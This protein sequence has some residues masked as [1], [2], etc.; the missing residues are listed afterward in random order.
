MVAVAPQQTLPGTQ[1]KSSSIDTDA[2]EVA[3]LGALAP[4]NFK[5][6]EVTVSGDH[7]FITPS[8]VTGEALHLSYVIS[9]QDHE[10]VSVFAASGDGGPDNAPAD[11]ELIEF[12]FSD[13]LNISSSIYIPE[14]FVGG[15]ILHMVASFGNMDIDFHVDEDLKQVRIAMVTRDDVTRGDVLFKVSD[16]YRWLDLTGGAFTTTRPDNPKIIEAVRDFVDDNSP[17]MLYYSLDVDLIATANLLGASINADSTIRSVIDFYIEDFIVIEDETDVESLT[18]VELIEKLS[19]R[20]AVIISS[21]ES[22]VS[23]SVNITI[24]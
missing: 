20:P 4:L 21:Y 3:A 18:D 10:G 19:I 24:L 2:A 7:T 12:D 1:Y 11:I 14:G 17:Q 22:G 9:D 23:A 16:T 15:S 8:N 13:P 6:H 5:L